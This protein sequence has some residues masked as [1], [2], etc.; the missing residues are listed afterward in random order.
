MPGLNLHMETMKYKVHLSHSFKEIMAILQLHPVFAVASI[1]HV[2]IPLHMLQPRYVEKKSKY[3]HENT[4]VPGRAARLWTLQFC[5][6]CLSVIPKNTCVTA[7]ST[8]ERFMWLSN[9]DRYI[10]TAFSAKHDFDNNFFG[11]W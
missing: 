6:R 8:V 4:G 7:S 5:I 9:M 11:V 2:H 10:P 1:Y 3:P